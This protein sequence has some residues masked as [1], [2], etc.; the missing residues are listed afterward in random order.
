V[1]STALAVASASVNSWSGCRLDCSCRVRGRQ[2]SHNQQRLWQAA[3]VADIIQKFS[4][5]R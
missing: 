4:S 5:H 2:Q 3:L 1:C